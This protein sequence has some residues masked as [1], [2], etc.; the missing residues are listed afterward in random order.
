MTQKIGKTTSQFLDQFKVARM[1]CNS[2]VPEEEFVKVAT[3]GMSNFEP[4]KHIEGKCFRD[5]TELI[6]RVQWYKGIQEWEME[7][8]KSENRNLLMK[9]LNDNIS[10]VQGRHVNFQTIQEVDVTEIVSDKVFTC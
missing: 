3:M 4:V 7:I 10:F 9:K 1:R 8:T 5:L 2:G 6:A